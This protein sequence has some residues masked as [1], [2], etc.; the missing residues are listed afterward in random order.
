MRLH[1]QDQ[2]KTFKEAPRR[3]QDA[4]KMPLGGLQD[5]HKTPPSRIKIVRRS[6]RGF[7]PPPSGA[8]DSS[9]RLQNAKTHL[10]D[11]SK[12]LPK[13]QNTPKT[14]S[15][16]PPRRLQDGMSYE[17]MTFSSPSQ[18]TATTAVCAQAVLLRSLPPIGS[19]SEITH[20]RGSAA[21]A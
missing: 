16:Q 9:R 18:P 1:V 10:Q 20:R 3:L 15:R 21:S 7:K 19:T 17:K 6:T 14:A 13:R 5:A 8:K 11:G 12:T 4:S 2:K